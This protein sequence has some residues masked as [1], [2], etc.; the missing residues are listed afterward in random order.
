MCDDICKLCDFGASA[1]F[2]NRRN[3]IVGTPDYACPE[4]LLGE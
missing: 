1:V 3:T 2:T 4:V